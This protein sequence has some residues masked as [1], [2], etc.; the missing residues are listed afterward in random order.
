MSYLQFLVDYASGMAEN[1]WLR[2]LYYYG[3]IPI[4]TEYPLI[5][6]HDFAL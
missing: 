4:Y 6:T 3:S 1:V 5:N 2:F